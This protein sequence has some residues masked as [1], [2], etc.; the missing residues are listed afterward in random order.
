M[1]QSD[2]I[3]IHNLKDVKRHTRERGAPASLAVRGQYRVSVDAK[4]SARLTMVNSAPVVKMSG[5]PAA[6]APVVKMSGGPDAPSHLR[7]NLTGPVGQI[8]RLIEVLQNTTPAVVKSMSISMT[9]A[10]PIDA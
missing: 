3:T 2:R 6:S 7:V 10:T 5:G 9:G 4:A 1:K 8:V